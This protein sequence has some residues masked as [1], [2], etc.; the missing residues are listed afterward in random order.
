[1]SDQPAVPASRKLRFRDELVDFWRFIRRPNAARLT[2]RGPGGGVWRDFWPGV[3][4]GR[5]LAWALLLW[6]VNLFALGPVAVAAAG[7]AG[8]RIGWIPPTSLADRHHLGAAGRGNAVPLWPATAQAGAVAVPGAGA[9][10]AVGP[11]I[12]T[13]LLLAAFLLL[14]VWALIR[15]AAAARLGYDL[16]SLLPEA[17]RSGVPSGHADLRRRAPEQFR[18]QQDAVL[19]AALLV[20]PQWLTGLALGWMRVR[21]GIGAAI[22][23]HAVFNAGPIVLIW[24]VMRW[25]PG[26]PPSVA[27]RRK[28][29]RAPAG[30]AAASPYA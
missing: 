12:W 24:A 30:Q 15:R 23:L 14:A 2:G 28:Q 19:A 8:P 29:A 25:V 20:L 18:L 1:M 5:L 7:L 17:F 6:C 27:C 22:A 11:R 21:R 9:R 3:R 16:A 26:R 13:G 10:G 4:P